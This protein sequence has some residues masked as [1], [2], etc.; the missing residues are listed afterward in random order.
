MVDFKIKCIASDDNE[1]FTIG[2]IYLV[3]NNSLKSDAYFIF[4]MWA[5]GLS[6]TIPTIDV[7][8]N[9]FKP[10][11]EFELVEDKPSKPRLCEIC[12]LEV[13]EPFQIK[14]SGFTYR[15]NNLGKREVS[16]NN[17]DYC[18][19]CNEERLIDIINHPE[20]IIYIPQFSDD[21]ISLMRLCTKEGLK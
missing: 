10:Y 15:I 16:E 20:K 6:G 1:C 19:A 12:N 14:G 9:W 8:N 2:K 18:L 4:Y 3:K 21:D 7:I 13:D 11:S 5:H 17:V